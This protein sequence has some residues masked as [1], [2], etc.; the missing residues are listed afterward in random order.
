VKTGVVKWKHDYEGDWHVISLNRSQYKRERD[1]EREG[2]GRGVGVR[3]E[4]RIVR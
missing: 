1:R 2:E 4:S 3:G